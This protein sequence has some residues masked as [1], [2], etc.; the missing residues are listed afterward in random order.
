M[1]RFFQLIGATLLTFSAA[2][3]NAPLLSNASAAAPGNHFGPPGAGVHLEARMTR[4]QLDP[5]FSFKAEQGVVKIN[6]LKKTVSLS[7]FAPSSGRI[8]EI[9][10]P[11]I[12]PLSQRDECGAR[13]ILAQRDLRSASGSFESLTLIDH[14][15]D[16]CD[17]YSWRR[18][19]V[20]Q[21]NYSTLN[22]KGVRTTESIFEA[23]V[24]RDP[25]A[26]EY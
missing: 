17:R 7:L 26:A 23:G 20:T 16:Y 10:L 11:I 19:A 3:L 2:S 4:V 12:S 25:S 13:V 6:R 9:R 18:R 14:S 24:L 5:L 15:T 8:V 21:I 22:S 1:G